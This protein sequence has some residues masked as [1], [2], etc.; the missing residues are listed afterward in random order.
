[1]EH[2]GFA[3]LLHSQRRALSIPWVKTRGK[4]PYLG[5]SLDEPT[6][7]EQSKLWTGIDNTRG[8]QNTKQLFRLFLKHASESILSINTVQYIFLPGVTLHCLY[9]VDLFMCFLT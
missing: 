2:L 1:M 8:A 7:G 5:F 9:N 3:E 4:Y 6:G